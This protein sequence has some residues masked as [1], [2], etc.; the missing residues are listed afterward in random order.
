MSL[1]KRPK[2]IDLAHHLS[3]VARKRNVSPLK[4]LQ[5]Y[6]NNDD[7]ISLA[8]G[9]PTPAY[10]PFVNIGADVLNSES[11]SLDP[12][13]SSAAQ[14][15]SLFVSWLLSMLGS[16]GPDSE[17]TTRISVP[18]APSDEDGGLNLSEALQYGAATG[19]DPTQEFIQSFTARVYRPGYSD[20]A[21]LVHGGN[22]DGWSRIVTTFCNPGDTILT[23]EWTYP[24]A[25]SAA[26]PYGIQVL[27]V[28]MDGEGLRADS[29]KDVL[30]AWD[31]GKGKRPHVLYT[32][33]VGQNPSGATLGVNRRKEIYDVCVK[34][35][36]IIAEDDPYYYLQLGEYVPKASRI[37]KTQHSLDLKDENKRFLQSLEPTFLHLDYQGRVVRLDSFSKT[38]A[39]GVRLGWFTCNPLFANRLERHGEVTMQSPCGLGQSLVI[40][41]LQTW[42][43][44]GYIRWIRVRTQRNFFLDQLSGAFDLRPTLGTQEQGAWCGRTVFT[45][46]AKAPRTLLPDEKAFLGPAQPL[47]SFVPPSSGMYVWVK[48]HFTEKQ[49]ASHAAVQNEESLERKLWIKIADA[50]VLTAPGWF[51]ST[52]D[53]VSP[54]D[55]NV[56]GHMRMSFSQATDEKMKE[57]VDIFATQL[58][59]FF[60]LD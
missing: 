24:S 46:Y 4:G 55:P 9:M 27:P 48:I 8:G 41:L 18:K 39:P 25:L 6:F 16:G 54:T 1:E 14:D 53:D 35:D 52:D 21:T 13:R 36:V 50:G 40:K 17:R 29:L 7:L 2:S 42:E 37:P 44:D 58:K 47:F 11:F 59:K 28:G 10:F 33:P 12:T 45:A 34:Y 15:K 49:R 23:E 51:F 20:F 60:D 32:I 19:M 22:T 38:I 26:K 3:E 31:E 43:F 56:E 30:A 57:G 5:K